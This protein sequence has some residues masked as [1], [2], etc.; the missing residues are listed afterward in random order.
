[1]FHAVQ[2]GAGL[3]GQGGGWA[4]A[5]SLTEKLGSRAP[6]ASRP[7]HAGDSFATSREGRGSRRPPRTT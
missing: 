6:P 7:C 5:Q 2:G 3:G 4:A 1:M